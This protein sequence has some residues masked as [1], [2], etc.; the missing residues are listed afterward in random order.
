LFRHL[1]KKRLRLPH[2]PLRKDMKDVQKGSSGLRAGWIL[3]LG[4]SLLVQPAK[5]ESVYHGETGR[6]AGF[7][8]ARAMDVYSA[9]AV[10]KIYEGLVQ[11]AYLERPYRIES[12]LAEGLPQ[13]SAD[14]LDYT[15]HLRHGIFFQDDPCFTLS[16]GHGREL[17]ADDFVYSLKRVADLKVASTGYWAFRGRIAGLDAFRERSAGAPADYAASVEGLQALDRYTLRIRLTRPFPALLWVLAMNYAFAVPREAVDYYGADFINH[18]VGTG[19]FVL[20]SHIH[21]YRLEFVRNPKWRQTG[22]GDRY[23][24]EGASGDEAAGLLRDAGQAVPF[25]DRIVQ[26]VIGDPSSQWLMFLSGELETSG[27]SRDN[28]DAVISPDRKL[29]APLRE[30]GIIMDA[31]PALDTTYI[32]FNIEDPVVGVNKP[33]RQALMCAFDRQKWVEFQNGR[34]VPASGPIPPAMSVR[35]D[36]VSPHPFDLARARALMTE[37]GYPGGVDPKTGRRLELFLELG[38]GGSD[39]RETA[40]VIASFMERIGVVIRPSFNNWPTMLKKIEQ[41]RA[42]MFLMSW[43]ADYPDPENFLQLFFGPNVTPGANRT[44]YRNTEFDQLYEQAGTLPEG[45]EKRA[46][47]GRMERLVMEDCP[48]LFIHH[49]MAFGLRHPWLENYKRHDFPYGMSKYLKVNDA[50][51]SH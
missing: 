6:I 13:L 17:T 27:I 42:Q 24:A 11:Y 41:R 21:N 39:T 31:V 1:P 18:P 38:S 23:P 15:F 3:F 30:R 37:A 32:G 34:V 43:V 48:W 47:Y 26:Y 4:A 33:L 20:S 16:G 2:Q 19:P 25:V 35:D 36:D 7:D 49:S 29:A 28:W 46:L 8:P 50:A 12:C 22:R 10:A 51:R 45:A 44:N 5:A 14:G 40:E 9:L